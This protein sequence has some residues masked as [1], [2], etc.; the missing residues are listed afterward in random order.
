MS[1]VGV[2]SG[3]KIPDTISC[4]EQ[5]R[6]IKRSVTE[7][8]RLVI[9][10]AKAGVYK[11]LSWGNTGIDMRG[12]TTKKIK[13]HY[14]SGMIH[15]LDDSTFQIIELVL[16]GGGK[17]TLFL[18]NCLENNNWKAFAHEFYGKLGSGVMTEILTIRKRVS[19]I[20]HSI[21]T[22]IF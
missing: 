12:K 17:L 16:N 7:E 10:R 2:L 19:N 1:Y 8:M 21:K 6:I 20:L 3:E 15:Y 18:K 5:G 4:Y 14:M 9:D 22:A 13:A 11:A